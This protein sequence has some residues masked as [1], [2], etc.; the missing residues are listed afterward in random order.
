MF[1]LVVYLG[2]EVWS[3]EEKAALE[4]HIGNQNL[5]SPHFISAHVLCGSR[6][7]DELAVRERI[8]L[9]WREEV[10]H[11]YGSMTQGGSQV[12][13]LECKNMCI[14]AQADVVG[15]TEQKMQVCWCGC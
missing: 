10:V 4:G 5:R 1:P 7:K 9:D 13:G 2:P 6:I 12:Q 14:W 11:I 3:I 15:W 8:K